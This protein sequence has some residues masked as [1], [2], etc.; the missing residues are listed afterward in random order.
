[1]KTSLSLLSPTGLYFELN[2]SNLAEAVSKV[3]HIYE[4][5]FSSSPMEGVPVCVH[6]QHVH[7]EVVG[8]QVHRLENLIHRHL[9]G[10][11]HANLFSNLN[12]FNFKVTHFLLA[13][14]LERFLDESEQVLLVH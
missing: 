7:G 4:K 6:V 8:S 10:A 13:V 11:I 3:V 12:I 14:C 2:L 5:F 1:M 9:V